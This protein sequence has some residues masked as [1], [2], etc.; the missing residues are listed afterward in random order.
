MTDDSNGLKREI[1]R[2]E[3][4]PGKRYPAELKGRAVQWAL[5]RRR[6][7]DNW[8][9]IGRKV[10]LGLDTVRRWCEADVDAPGRARHRALVPV[11][12]VPEPAE[13]VGHVSLTGWRIDGLTLAEAAALLRTFG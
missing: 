3:R 10:G 6:K 5:Q 2:C 4:G 13:S 11:Q 8:T 12:V 7:G 9:T 1:R